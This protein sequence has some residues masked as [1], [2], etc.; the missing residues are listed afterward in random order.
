[1]IYDYLIMG[2]GPAGSMLAKSLPAKS[3]ILIIDIAK[4]DD[5]YKTKKFNHPLVNFCSKKYNISYSNR[6]GGNSV[7][8]NNKLSVLTF[9]E[10]RN[11]GFL[12][13]YNEYKKYSSKII[14]ILNLK[15]LKKNEN[16]DYLQV[17]RAKLNNIYT[18]INLKKNKNIKIFKNHFPTKIIFEKNQKKV[19]GITFENNKKKKTYYFKKDLILCAGNFG[20]VFMLKNFFKKVKNSGKFLCDH[21][22]ISVNVDFDLS[23]KFFEYQKK[24]NFEK[25]II[26][27]KLYINKGK[28]N[29]TVQLTK[30]FN[31]NSKTI[32]AKF[33][34]ILL[35][36]LKIKSFYNLEFVLSQGKNNHRFIKL[37]QYS[38]INGLNK[39]DVFYKLQKNELKNIKDMIG[40]IIKKKI[41]NFSDLVIGNHPCCSN[42]MGKNK[43]L[44][45][46]DK[47][48]KV[49]KYKNVYLC[50]SD[51]FPNSGVTNPTFTIM[52]L[53]RRLALYLSRNKK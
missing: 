31:E 46:V 37:N 14:K 53:S 26:Y 2:S 23:K 8:W 52:V 48:L 28:L 50:G 4:K 51:V 41:D 21:P 35:H 30:N 10:F 36:K 1:M 39:L 43:Y 22:H 42:P 25:K 13:P 38:K 11:M 15:N 5:E 27:E 29:F 47:N 6:L 9:N 32:F 40:Q 20:N 33:I 24:F 18:L 17:L 45:V 3:K 12:F 34:K 19:K 49:H 16:S 7:L 44:S